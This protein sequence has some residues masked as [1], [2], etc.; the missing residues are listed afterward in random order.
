[1]AHVVPLAHV[2]EVH[3]VEQPL[4]VRDALR[5]ARLRQDEGHATE[6]VVVLPRTSLG[7]TVGRQVL[8]ERE[9]PHADLVPAAAE[10]RDDVGREPL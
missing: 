10:L 5:I 3:G 1:M 2:T 9:R 7:A 4:Q 6:G 8:S